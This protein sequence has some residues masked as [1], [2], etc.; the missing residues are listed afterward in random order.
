MQLQVKECQYLSSH[1]NLFIP[2][3]QSLQKESTL[4]TAW[5][6]ELASTTVREYISVLGHKIGG[7]LLQQS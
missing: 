3:P 4:P 6:Q 2:Q 5:L 1:Q 7:Y